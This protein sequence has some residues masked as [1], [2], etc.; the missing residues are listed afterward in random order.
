MSQAPEKDQAVREQ[1]VDDL[2]REL[3]CS[4]PAPHPP[5]PP[6]DPRVVT[7]ML[8]LRERLSAV[9]RWQVNHE[10]RHPR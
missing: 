6:V 2:V 7:W 8:E 5:P 4:A 3:G 1:I 9:E 10:S